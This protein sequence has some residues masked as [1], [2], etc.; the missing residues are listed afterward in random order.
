MVKSHMSICSSREPGF[1]SR[2]PHG[3]SPLSVTLVP[4][5]LTP[6]HRY[7]CRQNTNEH[8][9]KR[10]TQRRRGERGRGRGRGRQRQRMVSQKKVGSKTLI[11]DPE[12]IE[13]GLFVEKPG[14]EPG[15]TG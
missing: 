12:Y 13:T 15:P 10:G 7:T 11:N 5:F 3:S 1:N 9:I 14:K 8:K 6:S 4:G 2:Y